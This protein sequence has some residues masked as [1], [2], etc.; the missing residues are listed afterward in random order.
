MSEVNIILDKL[1]DKS[2]LE[3]IN[4]M[5]SNL[6]I[7]Q[8]IGCLKV[9]NPDE[10]NRF[11]QQNTSV[12]QSTKVAINYPVAPESFDDVKMYVINITRNSN[13]VPIAIFPRC[14]YDTKKMGVEINTL[15]GT[16]QEPIVDAAVKNT[17]S[18]SMLT[19]ALGSSGKRPHYTVI[20]AE[21]LPTG[22]ISSYMNTASISEILSAVQST[23]PDK[24]NKIITPIEYVDIYKRLA[25][26]L[27]IYF[28]IIMGR[29]KIVKDHKK[30]VEMKIV[31]YTKSSDYIPPNIKIIAGSGKGVTL[32]DSLIQKEIEIKDENLEVFIMPYGLGDAWKQSVTGEL[33]Y[34]M[35]SIAQLDTSAM[36]SHF[37]IPKGKNYATFKNS[38]CVLLAYDLSKSKPY[39]V[40]NYNQSG[41]PTTI[42][43]KTENDLKNCVSLDTRGV[44]QKL[45]PSEVTNAL[46]NFPDK[47]LAAPYASRVWGQFTDTDQW[48]NQ[49]KVDLRYLNVDADAFMNRS[50]DVGS[51]RRT[52]SSDKMTKLLANAIDVANNIS[53]EADDEGAIGASASGPISNSLESAF[54]NL[55]RVAA[56]KNAYITGVRFGKSGLNF[57]TFMFNPENERWS[58]DPKKKFSGKW[59]SET[60]LRKALSSKSSVTPS[61]EGLHNFFEMKDLTI[62]NT[63]F[64]FGKDYQLPPLHYSSFGYIK[65]AVTELNQRERGPQLYPLGKYAYLKGPHAGVSATFSE[66]DSRSLG[67][68][69]KTRMNASSAKNMSE[70]QFGNKVVSKV[71]K[72]TVNFGK[73]ILNFSS[74]KKHSFGSS[75][76]NEYAMIRSAYTGKKF[77]GIAT[78]ELSYKGTQ[79]PY[80]G[81]TGIIGRR[82]G[83]GRVTKPVK[84]TKK[85]KKINK[86][87]N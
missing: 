11:V 71:G 16:K 80:S 36:K 58:K 13:I 73:N 34:P 64:K 21:K 25:R 14:M 27:E 50:A 74:S 22:K 60:S 17:E 33:Y 9:I 3:I 8:L 82:P 42:E 67:L 29:F 35:H 53:S 46:N 37:L 59:K 18:T 49:G 38:T 72:K 63:G 5:A 23:S 83:F 15:L 31:S 54:G 2:I 43:W 47:L 69:P 66:A 70:F 86:A 4:W 56:L 76:P 81:F 87:K 52:D 79:S 62:N 44:L 75:E 45:I 39:L 30:T 1:K 84:K 55:Q 77:P 6:D 40:Q 28:K 24:I 85:T 68:W 57:L 48:D 51:T 32:I 65:K 78:A 19:L 26:F 20:Y 41:K 10:Y 7:S 12:P 61:E